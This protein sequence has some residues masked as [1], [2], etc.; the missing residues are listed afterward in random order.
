MYATD[1]GLAEMLRTGSFA[2]VVRVSTPEYAD[3]FPAASPART[4]YVYEVF[5]ARPV[6]EYEVPLWLWI[7]VKFVQPTPVQ[8]S[9]RYVVTPT[10]S[11]EA[12]HE[13]AMEVCVMAP[14]TGVL[15]VVGGV[16]SLAVVH[17][18]Y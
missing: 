9:M 8:R 4:R 10:A 12:D 15:G 14:A 3:R 18:A 5:V 6:L 11:V 13:S 16:V 1:V 17:A 2:V 7:C